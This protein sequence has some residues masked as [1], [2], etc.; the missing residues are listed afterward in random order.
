MSNRCRSVPEQLDGRNVAD[1][2]LPLRDGATSLL[3]EMAILCFSNNNMTIDGRIAF[4]RTAS[5]DGEARRTTISNRELWITRV[6]APGSPV[7]PV[8]G[9]VHWSALTCYGSC[10][11]GAAFIVPLSFASCGQVLGKPAR[12]AENELE[13]E[14]ENERAAMYFV[15]SL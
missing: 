3:Y 2:V 9:T 7:P 14:R 5:A 11:T 1:K 6:V 15:C 8:S 4:G 12:A 13:D 10:S